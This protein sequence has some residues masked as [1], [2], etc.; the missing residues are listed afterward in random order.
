MIKIGGDYILMT[1]R[2]RTILFLTFLFL[3]ILVAPLV[4]L[5]AQGYRFDFETKRIVQT[6]AFYFRASPPGVEIYI[7]NEF[8]KRTSFFFDSALIESLLPKKYKIEIKKDGYSTWTKALEIKEK[9]VLV[10]KNIILFPENP[11]FIILVEGVEKF[12]FSPDRK[13]IILKEV[14]DDKWALKLYNPERNIKSHLIYEKDLLAGRADLL[15]VEFSNDS[16]K[17][18]LLISD[19]K[20]EKKFVLELDEQPPVPR[21]KEIIQGPE[22]IV[23]ST[24][25]YGD[26]YSLDNFGRLFRNNEKLNKELFAIQP[27]TDYGLNIFRERIFLRENKTLHSF[28]QETKSFEKFFDHLYFLEISPDSKKLAHLSSHEIWILFLEEETNPPQR[29]TGE[30]LFLIRFSEKIRDFFW[31]NSNYL[32]LNVGNK[33]KIIEIDNRD[34]INA[35]NL[36]EFEKPKIFWNEIEKRLYVLSENNLFRSRI[37]LQ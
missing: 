9:E 10:T 5:H 36:A 12:W 21:I 35:V 30:K 2:T 4:V 25:Y 6:G 27:E 32:I 23:A 24:I 26:N 7:N 31:L 33:I 28:N 14:Q 16:K 3:F 1:K 19:E 29:E 8:K 20:Q 18:F 22:N 34:R 37:L 17:V 13:K 15:E 11:D